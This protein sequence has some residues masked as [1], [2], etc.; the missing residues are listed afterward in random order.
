MLGRYVTIRLDEAEVKLTHAEASISRDDADYLDIDGAKEAL[1]AFRVSNILIS[2]VAKKE[3]LISKSI[4]FQ[5]E[6][7]MKETNI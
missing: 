5:T 7:C 4:R 6:R 1:Q 2:W 3:F